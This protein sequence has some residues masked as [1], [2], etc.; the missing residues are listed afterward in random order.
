MECSWTI[1]FPRARCV[2]KSLV[3]IFVSIGIV[4]RNSRAKATRLICLGERSHQGLELPGTG[5]GKAIPLLH[6]L[7]AN[8]MQE[9]RRG[10]PFRSTPANS[11]RYIP[12]ASSPAEARAVRRKATALP[13]I[14]DTGAR[15]RPVLPAAVGMQP[16][17]NQVHPE[18]AEDRGQEPDDGQDRRTTPV[19]A[20]GDPGV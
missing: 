9:S 12:Q 11:A 19:P 17:K 1:Y 15:R 4:A 2:P 18:V 6:L 5:G 8:P 14:N 3:K 20:P 7:H 16:G 10:A 13:L